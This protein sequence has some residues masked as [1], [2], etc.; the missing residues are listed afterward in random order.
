[1]EKYL[2]IM[3]SSKGIIGIV[4]VFILIGGFIY[5][6]VYNTKTNKNMM[7]N[8]NNNI[9]NGATTSKAYFAG[10]CFWCTEGDFEKV[11]G[12]IEVISGY[13][14]GHLDNP[15]YEDVNTEK[16][17]HRESVEVI[18]DSTKVN[19]KQLVQYFMEHIDPT[20]NGG[21]FHDRGESYTTAI[22]YKT[23]SE[24]NIAD[25]VIA[26]ANK[27]GVY[28]KPIA[29]KVLAFSNFYKAEDYH[30]NYHTNN[31]VRYGYYRSGSGRDTYI[32]KVCQ[33]KLDKKLPPCDSELTG[34]VTDMKINTYTKPSETQIKS[35]L[36]DEQYNVTQKS[37]TEQPFKNA[38]WDNHAAGIYVDIVSGEPLF[39]SSDKYDSGTGWPSFIKPI[40]MQYIVTKVDNGFFSTRTEVRSKI[41]DSHLGH[42]FEDGPV[43]RGGKRYCMNSA[44]FRFIP[45]DQMEKDG[46][47]KYI[48]M[49]GVEK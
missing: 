36:T 34:N 49:V 2:K 22:F 26:D 42:V 9:I 23:E 45:K 10:G 37:G 41:A 3:T 19:Y 18:Y 24:K 4:L 29:V 5:G 20:D 47:G 28:D 12:V 33:I 31:P 39:S 38:Y 30:Q 7:D 17:G 32:A 15:K 21:Q 27:S 6:T 1:M 25:S 46:Y 14:G 40:D 13:A 43:E 35:M 11:P 44:A 16:T 48:S 8:T